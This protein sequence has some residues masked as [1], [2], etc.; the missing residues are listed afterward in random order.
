MPP[1]AL[2]AFLGDVVDA[3]RT[4]TQI[5]PSFDDG[6]AVAHAMEEPGPEENPLVVS[7]ELAKDAVT[8][9]VLERVGLG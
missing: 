2:S 5:T 8:R 6:V 7:V 3:L 9:T 4:G 1:P